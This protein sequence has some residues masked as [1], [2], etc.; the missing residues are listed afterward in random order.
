FAVVIF[1][2][3]ALRVVE[4]SAR[5]SSR[6]LITDVELFG[7][8]LDERALV[9][10]QRG[11]GETQGEEGNQR[12]SF[13]GHLLENHHNLGTPVS[14]GKP[15]PHEPPAPPSRLFAAYP[16]VIIGCLRVGAPQVT[17]TAT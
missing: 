13:H 15:W 1:G 17:S 3:G 16:I 11:R 4:D 12:D 8:R 14:L 2:Q 5:A 10:G 9:G 6:L 7:K